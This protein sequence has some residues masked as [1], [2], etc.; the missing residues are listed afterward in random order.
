MEKVTLKFLFLKWLR[1]LLVL[2]AVSGFMIVLDR[3]KI[4]GAVILN[5]GFS[6]SEEY[7][8]NLF[9]SETDQDAGLVTAVSPSIGISY[10]SKN[11]SLSTQYTASALFYSYTPLEDKL[12]HSLS[13]DLDIPLLNRQ[14]KG[15]EVSVIEEMSVSPGLPGISLGG[16]EGAEAQKRRQNLP[17]GTGQG[18]ELDRTDTFQNQAGILLLY[19]YS[20][21]LSLSSSYSHVYTRFSGSQFSDRNAHYTTVGAVYNR[22]ISPRTSW[23]GLYDTAWTTGDA[24]DKLIHTLKMGMEY[25]LTRLVTAKGDA[26]FSYFEDESPKPVFSGELSK[27]FQ[28]GDMSVRYSSRVSTGLGVIRSVTENQS[29]VGTV[30]KKFSERMNAYLQVSHSKNK[31]VSTNE[32]DVTTFKGDAGF[33]VQLLEWLNGELVYSY[34]KQD[35]QEGSLL[36]Q[37][38]ER[39]LVTFSLTAT[40]PPWRVLK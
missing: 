9:F 31:A 7:N 40:S 4:Y 15:V 30:N 12:Y 14:I 18:V 23:N 17:Q 5:S 37:D 27:R 33:F 20:R 32:V 10:T 29:V 8:D 2:I 39:N 38:G 35:S 36:G 26:G 13:I 21:Y 6:V 19:D 24:E 1:V 16:G 28:S 25:R 34:L 11:F 22:S 3:E